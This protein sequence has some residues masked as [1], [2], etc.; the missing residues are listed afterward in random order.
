VVVEAHGVDLQLALVARG[1]GVSLAPE[2]LL[3][4]S[5]V[6]SRVQAFRI[7]GHDCRIGVWLVSG[8]LPT[9]FTPVA[10]VLHAQLTRVLCGTP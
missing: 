5:R 7:H 6:R 2:P 4:R 9:M 10:T 8:R 1:A 3:H